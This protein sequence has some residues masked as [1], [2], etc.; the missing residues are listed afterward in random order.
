MWPLVLHKNVPCKQHFLGFNKLLSCTRMARVVRESGS[1]CPYFTT[2]L[3]ASD[4]AEL[5]ILVSV[6]GLVLLCL[7]WGDEP[8]SPNPGLVFF[9]AFLFLFSKTRP[10]CVTQVSSFSPPFPPIS[11]LDTVVFNTF[12]KGYPGLSLSLLSAP[13]SSPEDSYPALL[14]TVLFALPSL[15]KDAFQPMGSRGQTE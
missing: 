14:V 7:D 9:L 13:S 8:Q 3:L 6:I 1:L 5:E 11:C 12:L 4:L 10:T 15:P 2:I